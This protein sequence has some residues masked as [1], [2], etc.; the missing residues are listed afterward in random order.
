MVLRGHHTGKN[1]GDGGG[2]LGLGR[3][4]LRRDGCRGSGSMRGEEGPTVDSRGG[5]LL[6]A[7]FGVT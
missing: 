1:R 3:G 2:G 7:R 4:G 6:V 5:V